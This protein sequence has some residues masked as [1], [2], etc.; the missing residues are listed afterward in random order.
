M[1]DDGRAKN[2]GEAALLF[3]AGVVIILMCLGAMEAW[4]QLFH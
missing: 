1:K 4:R 2:W 3:G